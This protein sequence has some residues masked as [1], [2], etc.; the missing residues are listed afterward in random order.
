[1]KLSYF[2][3]ICMFVS[4][5]SWGSTPCIRQGIEDVTWNMTSD[6]KT[7]NL[8]AP[9]GCHCYVLDA[10]AKL[11]CERTGYYQ[12]ES[13]FFDDTDEWK[14]IVRLHLKV[15]RTACVALALEDAKG[16]KWIAPRSER[17]FMTDRTIYLG[18]DDNGLLFSYSYISNTFYTVFSPNSLQRCIVF[19]RV[20]MSDAFIEVPKAMIA[21]ERKARIAKVA[22]GLRKEDIEHRFSRMRGVYVAEELPAFL[23]TN[24][25]RRLYLKINNYNNVHYLQDTEKGLVLRSPWDDSMDG[26]STTHAFW[27]AFSFDGNSI[28]F[29]RSAPRLDEWARIVLEGYVS[30]KMENSRYAEYLR[31]RLVK[32]HEYVRRTLPIW[33]KGNRIQFRRVDQQCIVRANVIVMSSSGEVLEGEARDRYLDILDDMSYDLRPPPFH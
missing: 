4:S 2:L 1:M 20:P 29:V 30:K 17:G 15:D 28:R 9:K 16:R 26:M 12:S 3:F 18:P 5:L 19:H 11:G 21:D 27:G 31:S 32:N 8:R 14:G 25:V 23:S 24:G 22:R 7:L 6:F 13:V 10:L 33:L